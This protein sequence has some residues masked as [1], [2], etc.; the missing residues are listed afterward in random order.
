MLFVISDEIIPETH[1]GGHERSATYGIMIGFVVM[2]FL[3]ITL[4]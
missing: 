2:M 3:D 4:G 1:R